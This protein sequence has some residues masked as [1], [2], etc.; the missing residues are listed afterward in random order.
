MRGLMNIMN[1]TL[2][3]NKIY[4]YIEGRRRKVFVG[5]LELKNKLSKSRKFIF[6]YDKKYL[7][8][9]SSIPLGPDIPLSKIKHESEGKLF[10]SFKDRIPSKKNPAYEDYCRQEGI[11]IN[12]RN[13]IILLGTIGKRG[14][15]SFVFEAIYN[16]SYSVKENLSQFR[17]QTGLSRHDVALAFNL[18]YVTLNRVEMGTSTDSNILKLIQIYLEYPKCL[19]EQLILTSRLLHHRAEH[20]LRDYIEKKYN[21][22]IS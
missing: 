14:P 4:V 10:P 13:P 2:D 22:N 3:N 18:N 1:L 16:D 21:S 9:D 20:A 7:K 19:E 17:K 8:S 11:S 15:S 6:C 5:I 12:E